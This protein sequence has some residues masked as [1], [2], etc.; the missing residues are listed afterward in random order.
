MGCGYGV[1]RGT[2]V[3]LVV[4]VTDPEPRMFATVDLDDNDGAGGRDGLPGPRW[5]PDVQMVA[6][7]LAV[8]RMAGS[9][10]GMETPDRCWLVAGLSLAG[11]TAREIA[12]RCRCSERLVK[13]IRAEPM[14]ALCVLMQSET[15]RLETELR[16]ERIDHAATQLEL[17]RANRDVSRLRVQVGQMLDALTTDGSVRTC[18]K[19]HPLV[20]YNCY[21]RAGKSY[22]RQ[23]RRDWDARHRKPKAASCIS[24][25]R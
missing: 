11:L 3:A 7:V 10:T 1:A 19:G 5:A 8:P 24:V 25:T 6:A 20:P 2:G 4:C 23:C 9:L 16:V 21:E 18:S 15:G 13:A 14:T 12:H 22:C 17:A